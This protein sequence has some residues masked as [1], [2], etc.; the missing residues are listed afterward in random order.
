MFAATGIAAALTMVSYVI[1]VRA[2]GDPGE[3]LLGAVMGLTVAYWSL[4]LAVRRYRRHG[5]FELDAERG[6]LR[7]YRAGF[8]VGEFDLD[9]VDQVGLVIDPTDGVR[10][11]SLPSWLQV[12]FCTGEVF[13]IAKGSPQE[14]APVCA[15]LR[16]FGLPA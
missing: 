13:R 16:H 15:A 9:L 11:S 14:L 4:T 7:R 10:M 2:G 5:E 3:G 1:L 12:T 8:M 6:V